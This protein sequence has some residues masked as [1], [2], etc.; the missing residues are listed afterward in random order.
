MSYELVSLPAMTVMGMGMQTNNQVCEVEIP[1]FFQKVI[2]ENRF[3]Q[4]PHKIDESIV[5]CLYTDYP[6][7]FNIATS[8]YTWMVGMQV[9][10]GG[11]VPEDMMVKEIPAT[12]Y[13][14]FSC[15]PTEVGNTWRTIWQTPL[16]RTFTTD[17]ERYDTKTGEVRIYIAIK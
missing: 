9:S 11:S 12:N 3:I 13:A 4:I 2:T 14:M 1:T 5:I 7:N 17:F 16:K 15:T 6:A 10:D 8:P